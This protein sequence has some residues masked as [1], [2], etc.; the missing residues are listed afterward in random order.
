M[1]TAE[2]NPSSYSMILSCNAGV[3][4]TSYCCGGDFQNSS[5]YNQNCCDESFDVDPHPFG[6]PYAPAVG[7]PGFGASKVL[8]QFSV[9]N[10]TDQVENAH[11]N[12]ST[13][14]APG[15]FSKP[16]V[17][18][19]SDHSVAVGVGVGVPLGLL[20]LTSLG[21]LFRERSRTKHV[22]MLLKE[23]N[24]APH[25]FKNDDFRQ[26]QYEVSGPPRELGST[27]KKPSELHWIPL[28][29]L[30]STEAE[31]RPS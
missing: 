29:E 12:V 18:T 20:F 21:L 13:T 17:T 25:A 10:S 4:P 16:G 9:A 11:C 24:L 23:K 15:N 26:Y 3:F 7:I 14:A 28:T 30:Q 6:S 1:L 31:R 2:A 8:N 27:L 5:R 22:T 19:S